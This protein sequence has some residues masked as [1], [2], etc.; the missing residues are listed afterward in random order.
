MCM[1]ALAACTPV[2]QKRASEPTIDGCEPPSGYYEMTQDLWKKSCCSN[3]ESLLQSLD[4]SFLTKRGKVGLSSSEF[5]STCYSCRRPRFGSHHL[6]GDS[7]LS[8]S[9]LLDLTP[10]VCTRHIHIIE[11]AQKGVI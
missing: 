11:K 3:T 7:Q 4:F 6:H 5:M 10:S 2:R 1:S 9:I 8:V